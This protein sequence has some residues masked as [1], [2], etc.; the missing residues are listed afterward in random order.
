MCPDT[1]LGAARQKHA[2]CLDTLKRR[3][4]GSRKQME[5]F[6]RSQSE[7]V[8]TLRLA[9]MDH[10]SGASTPTSCLKRGLTESSLALAT[11]DQLSRKASFAQFHEGDSMLVAVSGLAEL[12]QEMAQEVSELRRVVGVQ[13]QRLAAVTEVPEGAACRGR[14]RFMAAFLLGLMVP[15]LA[16]IVGGKRGDANAQ[17][18]KQQMRSDRSR[19]K[20]DGDGAAPAVAKR[21]LKIGARLGSALASTNWDR[22]PPPVA[23]LRSAF[24]RG[25]WNR[26]RAAATDS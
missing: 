17:R 10:G 24:L 19:R 25:P 13:A 22:M 23:W 8:Q 5:Q 20:D 11:P 4:A 21:K 3:Q 12:Q 6:L 15:W 1:A 9:K 16:G 26:R 14:V 2:A 18:Q 7:A